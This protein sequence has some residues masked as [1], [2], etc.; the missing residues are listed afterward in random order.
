[1]TTSDYM[2]LVCSIW[3]V[4]CTFSIFQMSSQVCF[5]VISAIFVV[6]IFLKEPATVGGTPEIKK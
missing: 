4:N 5:L 1:M 6:A 3:H 2:S